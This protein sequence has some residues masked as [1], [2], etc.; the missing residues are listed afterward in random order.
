MVPDYIPQNYYDGWGNDKFNAWIFEII[1]KVYG[2]ENFVIGPSRGS[3]GGID[4]EYVKAGTVP[5]IIQIKWREISRNSPS[6]LRSEIFS[7]FKAEVERRS[8]NSGSIKYLFV[9]N[10][11]LTHQYHEKFKKIIREYPALNIEYWEFEKENSFLRQYEELYVKFC[12]YF[13]RAEIEKLKEDKDKIISELK[14]HYQ[15][16]LSES[17]FLEIQRKVKDLFINQTLQREYYYAFIYF[18]EPVYMD[19]RSSSDRKILRKLLD[20]TEQTELDFI[21]QLVQEGSISRTESLL[22]VNNRGRAKTSL[23]GFI[24]GLQIPLEKVVDMFEKWV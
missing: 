15:E 7:K 20:I 16:Q 3:D 6:K 24:D 4:A 2:S 10:V 11:S 13:T 8:S 14:D 12:P 22:S 19:G 17:E 1:K 18:L 21:G 23:N 9:T 5:F